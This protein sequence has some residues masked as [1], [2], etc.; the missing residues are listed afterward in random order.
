MLHLVILTFQIILTYQ[1]ILNQS[2]QLHLATLFHNDNDIH[3]YIMVIIVFIMLIII[4][5]IKNLKYNWC[6]QKLTIINRDR[7]NMWNF[8]KCGK[9]NKVY[10]IIQ[11]TFDKNSIKIDNKK[12][13]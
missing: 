1:S 5:M 2:L 7:K 11:K 13:N 6:G 10:S 9:T 3:D 8:E 4:S 12:T